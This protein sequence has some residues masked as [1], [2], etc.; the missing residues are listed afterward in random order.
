MRARRKR[1]IGFYTIALTVLVIC[2]VVIF[3]KYSLDRKYETLQQQ[4]AALELS[5]EEEEDRRKEI[6]EYSVYVRTKKFVKD[7]AREILGLTDPDD[8]IIKNGEE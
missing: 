6:E 2:G 5:I 8:I 1:R 7:F 4:K 3:S